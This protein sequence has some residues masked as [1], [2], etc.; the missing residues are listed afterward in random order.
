[1]LKLQV[2]IPWEDPFFHQHWQTSQVEN[3]QGE[4]HSLALQLSYLELRV[5]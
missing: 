1:M 5:L 4:L 3:F 2:F